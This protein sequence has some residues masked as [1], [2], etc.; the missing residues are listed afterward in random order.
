MKVLL[1]GAD[2]FIGKAVYSELKKGHEVIGGT[3]NAE[4][5]DGYVQLDLA[6]RSSIAKTLKE[7]RPEAIINCAGIVG[8]NEKADL[9]AVYVSNLLAE[10]VASGLT[11]QRIIIL[12]SAA[13]YGLVEAKDI[14]VD[15]ETPLRADSP[16]GMSIVKAEGVA[17]EYVTQYDLPIVVARIFNPI[18]SGMQPRFL[19]PSLISQLAEVKAGKRGTIEVSRLDSRRDY[20]NVRDLAVA[21]RAL[22]EHTPC[23]KVYNIGSGRATS[24]GQLV[25][26]ILE[27]SHLGMAPKLIETSDT[28]EAL[29]AVQAD[30]SRMADE[31]GWKTQIT[32]EDTI[33]EIIDATR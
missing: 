15:E 4:A 2:G 16:Y 17:T 5:G 28:P 22:L 1:I 29:V 18:G 9:N 14:P 32:V 11:F 31:F 8:N 12:G 25:E 10:A 27:E 13:E 26:M 23:Q 6:E 20:L 3:R 7:V 30:V 21:F 19:I 33:K 24:N